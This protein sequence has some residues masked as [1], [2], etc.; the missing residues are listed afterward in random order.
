[1]RKGNI[2]L[3]YLSNICWVPLVNAYSSDHFKTMYMCVFVSMCECMC[4]YECVTNLAWIE[5]IFQIV[6]TIDNNESKHFQWSC[7]CTQMK[8]IGRILKEYMQFKRNY[9]SR[10]DFTVCLLTCFTFLGLVKFLSTKTNVSIR[11]VVYIY[12]QF[13]VVEMILMWIYPTCLD[14]INHLIQNAYTDN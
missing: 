7:T 3:P 8:Y 11:Y 13:W 12:E 10:P 14:W 4:F 5:N 2:I 9:L 1:M 6:Q